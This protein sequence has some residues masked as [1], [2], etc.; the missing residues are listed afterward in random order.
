M[1]GS[2]AGQTIS[3]NRAPVIT[4]W[5]AVVAERL[6]YQRGEALTLGRAVAGLN[7]QSKGRRLGIMKPVE[8]TPEEKEKRRAK[9]GEATLVQLLGR[10]V[11]AKRTKEGL[12]AVDEK[13]VATPESV[14]RYLESKFGEAL[15]E[16][17]AAMDKLAAAYPPR[18][19]EDAAFGLY[20]KFRPAIPAGVKGW[21]AA[22]VLD[23]ALIK[24]M[25]RRR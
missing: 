5:A 11:T 23:L 3:V 8:R 21:G 18:E 2:S 17:R 9:I 1:S 7:A 25:A 22:G 15:G 6:G 4:L 12:R 24:R 20:E 16:A 10:G 14:E 19:L 13:G